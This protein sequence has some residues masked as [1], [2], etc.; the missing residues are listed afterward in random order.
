MEQEQNLNSMKNDITNCLQ[1]LKPRVV[2]TNKQEQSHYKCCKC[3][4][5]GR[6]F[7]KDDRGIEF[8]K[9]CECGFEAREV[10]NRRLRFANIPEK[11]KDVRF[12]NFD[13][14]I[15]DGADAKKMQEAFKIV[16]T[17]FEHFEEMKEQGRGLY[18]YS[19]CKGSGKT[20]LAISLANELI[21]NKNQPVK[22]ATSL[23]ILNEIK[24]TWN[25][26][27]QQNESQLLDNLVTTDVLIIDDFGTEK[28]KDWINEKFFHIIDGRYL[29]DKITIVTSNYDIK[30]IDYD[31]RIT[32]RLDE[33]CYKVEFP[34]KSVRRIN[35]DNADMDFMMK[36]M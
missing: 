18:L 16:A 4:D 22:F 6:Y 3:K 35:A 20:R 33:K 9:V 10:M 24:N 12:D 26:D 36:F 25:N 21:Y 29:N 19:T 17:Y 30:T 5:T 14:S 31:D 7:Y 23:Q 11:Y 34:N 27:T 15:F 32:S 2:Q 28:S 8:V 13:L 1:K